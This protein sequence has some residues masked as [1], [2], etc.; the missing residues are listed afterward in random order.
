MELLGKMPFI[1]M[2]DILEVLLK[3]EVFII[4]MRNS[5]I[6]KF[7]LTLSEDF[8]NLSLSMMKEGLNYL[9]CATK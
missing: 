1:K 2:C 8:F 4:L 3:P 7:S 9:G 6:L 5:T